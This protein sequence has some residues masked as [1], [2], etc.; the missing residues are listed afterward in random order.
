MNSQMATEIN[1]LQEEKNR[2]FH[3]YSKLDSQM[4]SE[5]L[6]KMDCNTLK[7]YQTRKSLSP[8]TTHHPINKSPVKVQI[9]G[10]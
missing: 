10:Y 5:R 2:L 7:L 6:S 1:K 9:N 4:K 8:F 3:Y